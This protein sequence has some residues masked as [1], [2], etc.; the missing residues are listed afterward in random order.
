MQTVLTAAQLLLPTGLISDPVLLIED[1]IVA[2]VC[3]RSDISLPANASHQDFP[4]ATIAPAYMDVHTHGCCGHDV[5][6]ATPSA[7]ETIGS[8]LATHGVGAY[9][10]TTI[11]ASKDVILR[12]LEGLAKRIAEPQKPGH[13]RPVGIHLEGPF[14][15]HAKR[16]THPPHDLLKPS[17]EFFDAMW[18]AAEGHMTLMT[19]APE[20]PGAIELIAHAKAKGVKLSIGHSD[21]TEQE[22]EAGIAAGAV[23][24]THTF[25]AMRKLDQRHPGILGTV[26]MTD[27]LFAEIICDG[28]HVDPMLVRLFSRVKRSDRVL[29][30]TDAM[31][32]VGMPDGIYKLGE[33]DVRVTGGRAVTGDD[34]LAGSTLTLDTA[35][36]NY[37]RFAG[38]PIHN[39]VAAATSNPARM[40]ENDGQYGSIAPGRAA[41]LNILS[42]T[43][44]LQA[45]YLGGQKVGD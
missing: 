41:D 22:A 15:S 11:T 35:V 4:E 31:S 27:D 39:A 2:H 32:A 16:G 8:F 23:S 37:M 14:L 42:A 13:A 10:P 5:M 9:L 6:E 21:S 26:L 1:G 7:M 19:I 40:T 36:A 20:L 3:T 25:N 28:L 38:A 43:G 33:L 17:I 34:T 18:Q 29:L 12:S 30:I 24:A 44:A 45:T